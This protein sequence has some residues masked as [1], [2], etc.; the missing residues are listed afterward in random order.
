M[1]NEKIWKLCKG[2]ST[3]TPIFKAKI[4]PNYIPLQ[5]QEECFIKSPQNASQC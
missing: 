3:C 4:K 2:S 5:G 1:I